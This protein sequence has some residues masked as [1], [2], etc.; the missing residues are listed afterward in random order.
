M[1]FET[2]GIHFLGDVYSAVAVVVDFLG[3]DPFN[4]N[5]RKFRSKT[6]WIGSVQAEKFRKN[7]S[8][9]EVVLFSRSD[10]SA[11]WLNGSGPCK[12]P[13]MRRQRELQKSNWW[14]TTTARASRSFVHFFT[15]L[16]DYDG[17]M[18]NFTFHRGRKQP[19]AWFSFSFW[20][21]MWFLGVRLKKSSLAF[22]KVNEFE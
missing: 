19:T 16:R 7:G 20:T 18:P 4:Q 8:P 2:A 1:K 3:R 13:Q 21:W 12:I 22:D 6:Q 14:Q 10:R 9:F 17:K 15:A 11:F 5:F